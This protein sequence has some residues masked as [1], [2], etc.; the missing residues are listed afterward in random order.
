MAEYKADPQKIWNEYSSGKTYKTNIGLYDTVQRNND[1]FNDK[2]WEGVRAPDLDKPVFNILKPVVNYYTAML[3]SDDIAVNVEM[4]SGFSSQNEAIDMKISGNGPEET[5]IAS[6][7]MDEIVPKVIAREVETIMEQA[8]VKTKNRRMIRNCAVDG[9][10]CFYMWFDPNVETGFEYKGAV[11]VDIVDN[12]NVYFGNP[13]ETDVQEQPYIIIAYRRLLD[14]VKQE[15]SENGLPV[16]EIVSDEDPTY[17]NEQKDTETQYTTVLLKLW[18]EKGIVHF[19]KTTEKAVVKKETN[20]ELK[21]YPITWMSW[22]QTKNSYHG[23]SPITGKINNQIFVNKIYALSM[24]FVANNAF[25]KVVYDR[26]KLPQGW[27][28][29]VNKAIG[30]AGDP[31]TAI[32]SGFRA[33]DM[34]Q[35]A[36]NVGSKVM[37]DTKD[38][39]GASD[40][41]LGNVKPDNTSAI[42]AV[43]KAAGLPLDIQRMEFHNFVESYVRI[44]IEMMRVY[45]GERN[46]FI[47]SEKTGSMTGEFDFSKLD[48]YAYNLNIDIGAGSYWSELMQVQTLDNL[49]ANGIIP[50]ALTYLELIPDGYV[51]NKQLVMDR[52]KNQQGIANELAMQEQIAAQP[53]PPINAETPQ[54]IPPMEQEQLNMMLDELRKQP[55]EMAAQI[56][57]DLAISDEEKQMLFAALGGV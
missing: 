15:A 2:Q 36:M 1:F 52:I 30:V 54:E 18:K 32:L 28:N 14:D 29:D 41:A 21:M 56:I 10:A 11:K 26:T 37:Q 33:P 3:I 46:I 51:K 16:D 23:V 43:Q 49:M 22:E 13:S 27:N 7:G 4:M 19:C 9:D 24:R 17:A 31:N 12:T 47:S 44:F 38:L 40:A 48:K 20:T 34:S 53:A 50:D 25:P 42:I 57:Q 45:Y 8:N 39:M 55:P 6:F 35:D 5:S